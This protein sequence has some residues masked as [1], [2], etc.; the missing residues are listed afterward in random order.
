MK[1]SFALLVGLI[2]LAAQADGREHPK[3][4]H[5]S[6]KTGDLPV[7]GTSK[8]QTGCLVLDI[9]KDGLNDIVITS[10]DV[11]ASMVWY[12]RGKAGWTIYPIDR[13]LNIEAGG[14]AADIDG[15]GDSDLVFGEDYTGSKL[16]WWENPLSS[17][18]RT[19]RAV[20][21]TG[22][23]E[24]GRDDAPRPDLRRLRR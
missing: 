16:Y 10:R 18:T 2:L 23:Q 7:P 15:D 4:T 5:L 3:W 11:G 19:N 24:L 8:Q 13:G 20:G 17:F 9:D 12:R 22:N 14:A 6:S 1:V 21:Q